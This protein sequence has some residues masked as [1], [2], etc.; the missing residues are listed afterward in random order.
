[1]VSA[2]KHDNIVAQQMPTVEF[3]NHLRKRCDQLDAALIIDEVRAGFRLT[4]GASW[5][6]LDIAPDL[7]AWSKAIANGYAL[8]AI[9]GSEKY[10]K[11]A[12]SVFTTGSFWFAAA[13][14]IAA[15]TTLDLISEEQ[16]IKRIAAMGQRFREGLQAQ[17]DSYGIPLSQS[18]PVQ[19]PLVLF[20]DDEVMEKKR[21]EVFTN[22][23]M[24]LGL[25]LHPR[26]NW[27]LN[28]GHTDEDI[29]EAL[30]ITDSGL[31]IVQKRF[32]S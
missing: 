3:A 1:M 28:G 23:A 9:L 18:G 16:V 20:S 32:Y 27:F 31:K 26:H 17:A 11:A 21:A 22:E 13:S 25:Y 14:M 6:L 4:E 24:K 30:G 8:A 12:R 7:T 5:E 29:D 15:I 2:F 19:M 10:R